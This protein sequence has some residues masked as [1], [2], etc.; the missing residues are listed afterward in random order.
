MPIII[1]DLAKERVNLQATLMACD[2]MNMYGQ[3]LE[4]L[5]QMN[6]Q[7]NIQKINAQKRLFE[8]EGQ[9]RNYIEGKP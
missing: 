7:M 2:Q 3:T 5:T 1:D 6:I 8:I 9:I 4:N